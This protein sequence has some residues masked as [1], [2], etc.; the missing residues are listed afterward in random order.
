M[1]VTELGTVQEVINTYWVTITTENLDTGSKSV[2]TKL[3]TEYKSHLLTGF[4][5]VTNFM[6]RYETGVFADETGV[7][8]DYY[9]A[10]LGILLQSLEYNATGELASTKELIEFNDI[11]GEDPTSPLLEVSMDVEDTTVIAST[12]TSAQVLVMAEGQPVQG[13]TIEIMHG[14]GGS[15]DTVLDTTGPEGTVNLTFT[16]DTGSRSKI[17][18]VT[19]M[20]RIQGFRSNYARANINVI[21]DSEAPFII[22]RTVKSAVEGETVDIYAFISDDIGLSEIYLNYRIGSSGAFVTIEMVDVLG[23]KKATI[24]STAISPPKV[25]YY[26]SAKDVNGNQAY[27]PSD[28]PDNW[29][30]ITVTPKVRILPVEKKPLTSGGAVEVVAAVRGIIDIRVENIA[31]PDPYDPYDIF[32]FA[33]VD[34]VGDGELVWANITFRYRTP[35]LGDLDENDLLVYIWDPVEHGWKVLDKTGVIPDE[36]VVWAN[37]T[38]PGIF[39]PRVSSIP[40]PPVEPDVISPTVLFHYPTDNERL[41]DGLVMIGGQ[42][43]DNRALSTLEI[44]V[45]DGDWINVEVEEGKSF[46]DWNTQLVIPAG[47]HRI[48]ARATDMAGNTGDIVSIEVMI[49]LEPST[50]GSNERFAYMAL[51]TILISLVVVVYLITGKREVAEPDEDE[52]H[53][54]EVEE[55]EEDLWRLDDLDVDEELEDLEEE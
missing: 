9:S 36:N 46:S 42:A 49:F 20:A 34:A 11:I 47:S 51:V 31:S 5:N 17:V 22:H 37:V 25:Q 7:I 14:P 23:A 35:T 6:G 41:D 29:H 53:G 27:E 18:N 55:E 24:P 28:Y 26:I 10:D 54:H 21:E 38:E 32:L 12:S 40:T 43:S 8:F 44:K 16:A 15:F 48:Y 50:E 13:A 39:A 1:S 3:E 45:D 30:N 19:A 52:E 2:V 33:G 4:N